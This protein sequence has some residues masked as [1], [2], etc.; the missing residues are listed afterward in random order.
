MFNENR[1]VDKFRV[2]MSAIA[3]IW[4]LFLGV[5]A[6]GYFYI[7]YTSRTNIVREILLVF[8]PIF[9]F[10]GISAIINLIMSIIC[11]KRNKF[12][13]EIAFMERK[14]NAIYIIVE[15]FIC[16]I[17]ASIP[18]CVCAVCDILDVFKRSRISKD[19]V[20]YKEF[21]NN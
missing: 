1:W 7:V 3:I 13:K 18:L 14:T 11:F 6:F 21:L 12:I 19:S 20:R 17:V 8:S 16:V 5:L 2:T 10:V 4:S 15:V 9:G